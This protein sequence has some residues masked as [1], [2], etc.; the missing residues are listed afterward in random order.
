V[1]KHLGN[2]EAAERDF[3]EAAAFGSPTDPSTWQWLI[4]IGRP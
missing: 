4:S 3:E 1:E 2:I